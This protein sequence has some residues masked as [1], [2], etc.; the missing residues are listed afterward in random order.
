MI[1][2]NFCFTA[3]AYRSDKRCHSFH[4]LGHQMLREEDKS[5]SFLRARDAPPECFSL[6][7]EQAGATDGGRKPIAHGMGKNRR[8]G[9]RG[10][11]DRSDSTASSSAASAKVG[12]NPSAVTGIAEV[13]RD[14]QADLQQKQWSRLRWEKPPGSPL[15]LRNSSLHFPEATES[16]SAHYGGL[17]AEDNFELVE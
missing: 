17:T 16:G 12:Q 6:L 7:C 14:H 1:G 3:F 2:R 10:R 15:F 8:S 4:S 5:T 11:T 9:G 13:G